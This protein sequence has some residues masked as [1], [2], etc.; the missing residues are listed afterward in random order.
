MLTLQ[1]DVG[2]LLTYQNT[3]IIDRIRN[4]PLQSEQQTGY[5]FAI[6]KCIYENWNCP[7]ILQITC[8]RNIIEVSPNLAKTQYTIIPI[9][10]FK[11]K[12]NFPK[13]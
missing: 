13:L 6:L 2:F 9:M 3:D 4:A 12:R 8:K 11:H 1:R 5:E 10:S 7:E